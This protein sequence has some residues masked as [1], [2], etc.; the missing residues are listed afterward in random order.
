[1]GA[2]FNSEEWLRW[3][4]ERLHA[5]RRGDRGAFDE[6]Y[7]AFAQPLFTQIL[8]PRLGERATAEDVLADTFRVLLERIDDFHSETTSIWFWLARVAM[9]KI[10]DVHRSQSRKQRALSNFETLLEPVREEVVS[11]RD[12][13]EQAAEAA[14][15]KANVIEVLARIHP[16]YRRVI[17]LRLVEERP[18]EECAKELD[19]KVA[20]FDVV[21]LRAVRAFRT[22]WEQSYNGKGTK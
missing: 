13:L 12:A 21:F 4:Q 1:M 5:A 7:R 17:E 16:R 9:N 20:T 22:E 2:S 6:L 11:P 8:M 18:R 3:E 15:L 10:T 14:S 19:V